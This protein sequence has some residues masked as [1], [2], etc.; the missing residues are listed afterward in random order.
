[1]LICVIRR[2]FSLALLA[3]AAP[4]AACAGET[5]CWFEDGVIVV[6]AQV[7]GVAGDWILD[8]GSAGSMLH[9]TRAQSEGVESGQVHGAVRLAGLVIP[10]R[11]AGVADL[12]ARTWNLPTPAAG[13][14][15]MDVLR[16]YVVDVSFAPC[17]VRIS[18][19]QDAP[20]FQVS[21]QL[22]LG[23][24]NG[25][26]TVEAQVTDG[27]R[28]L[29]G[30]FVISTGANVAVRL[31]DDLAAALPSS[32]RPGEL[33]PDGVWLARLEGLELAGTQSAPLAAGL[34]RPDGE[35]AAGVIG[36]QVLS[37]FRLRFDFPGSTL[38]LGP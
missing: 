18:R 36:A 23:W 25:R 20:A 5:A 8:T 28:A 9:E 6:P 17:R 21:R 34:V 10:D 37:R 24:E 4:A 16:D 35:A 32:E 11:T 33:Y 19:P 2:R 27:Q 22:P 13:V 15:G 29:R 12:D 3:A 26:P 30:P 7:A 31:A 14:I 1:M 38:S